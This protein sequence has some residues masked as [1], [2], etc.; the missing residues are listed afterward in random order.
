MPTQKPRTWVFIGA[1]LITAKT[2]KQ[3]R[4]LSVGNQQTMVYPDNGI[5]VSAKK[6]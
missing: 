5:L 4:C 1:L 3:P 6:K 2:W